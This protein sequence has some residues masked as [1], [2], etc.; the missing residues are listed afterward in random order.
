ME[1]ALKLV[2]AGDY[3]KPCAT[4]AFAGR[5]L[6]QTKVF[7]VGL[8]FTFLLWQCTAYLP[9]HERQSLGMKVL[10]TYQ[11]NC[12]ISS[13]LYGCCL[14]QQ[15]ISISLW[16]ATNSCLSRLGCLVPMG[17]LL[18][19]NFIRCNVIL[20]LEASFKTHFMR[21]NSCLKLPVWQ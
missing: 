14:Q 8:V 4:I 11:L 20:E 15:D 21:W 10:D 9:V 17:A 18:A 6:L 5:S 16:K 19:P 13:E 7:V 2:L 12:S 3:H 1:Q